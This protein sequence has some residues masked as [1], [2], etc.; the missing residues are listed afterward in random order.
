MEQQ[1]IDQLLMM[2]SSKLSP[3]YIEAI[4]SRLANLDDDK[5]IFAFADVKDPTIM[6][7][8]SILLGGL[9][10]DRFMIG[11]YVLGA[12]QLALFIIGWFLCFIPWIGWIIWEIIDWFLIMGA[13][14]KYNSNKVLER[15][16]LLS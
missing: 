13:T 2:H 6:L 12:G 11:D 15:L 4:R 5:S 8:I 10:V 9:G 14:R 3:E 16:T 1:K 7:I